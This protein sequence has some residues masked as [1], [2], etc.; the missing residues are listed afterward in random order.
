MVGRVRIGCAGERTRTPAW[1]LAA[2]PLMA[3]RAAFGREIDQARWGP[4]G[5]ARVAPRRPRRRGVTRA[6]LAGPDSLASPPGP[7]CA[8]GP[9]LRALYEIGVDD[10]PGTG[11]APA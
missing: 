8:L 4:R 1:P 5:R 10:V 7:G 6:S 3:S 11:P 9:G 2:R